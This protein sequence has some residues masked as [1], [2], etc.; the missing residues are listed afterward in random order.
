M[1]DLARATCRLPC[2]VGERPGAPLFAVEH[3]ERPVKRLAEITSPTSSLWAGPLCTNLLGLG[4]AR[5]IKV[6]STTRPDG[7][8][9]GPPAFFELLH[10]GE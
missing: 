8:R 3:A 1:R 6:E 7:A 9:S 2:S 5:V 4:G 10:H